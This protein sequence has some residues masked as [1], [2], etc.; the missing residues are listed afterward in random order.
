MIVRTGT[1]TADASLFHS[2]IQGGKFCLDKAYTLFKGTS[3]P[4]PWA[5]TLKHSYIIPTHR[6]I[7]SLA[8]QGHLATIDNLPT[9]GLLVISRCVLCKAANESHTHIFFSC[10]YSTALWERL[11]HLLGLPHRSTDY[12]SE[13]LWSLHRKRARHWKNGWFRSCIAAAC[14]HLWSDQNIRLFQGIEQLVDKLVRKNQFQISV[15]V[16]H[17]INCAHYDR[18]VQSLNSA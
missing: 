8:M 15:Q 17:N 5:P 1:Q 13:L 2:W 16:L 3:I 7:T 6:I 9:R 12:S 10:S 18:V 11:L 4:H 14:Y